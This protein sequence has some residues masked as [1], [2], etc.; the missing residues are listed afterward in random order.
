MALLFKIFST[1]LSLVATAFA[2]VESVR[3]GLFIASAIFA[4]AKVIVFLVFCLVLLFLLY[5]LLTSKRESPS[6]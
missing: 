3:R 5:T 1:L 6:N 2:L 4:I